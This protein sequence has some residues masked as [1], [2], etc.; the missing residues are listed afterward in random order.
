MEGGEAARAASTRGARQRG[1][2]VIFLTPSSVAT[3]AKTSEI[4]KLKSSSTVYSGAINLR[5]CLLLGACSPSLS[6]WSLLKSLEETH[7]RLD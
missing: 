2:H 4:S 5:R 6:L 7:F 1:I 3:R